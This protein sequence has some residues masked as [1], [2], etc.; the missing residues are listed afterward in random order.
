MWYPF[1]SRRAVR[2]S[3]IAIPIILATCGLLAAC[4]GGSTDPNPPINGLEVKATPA[5]AFTPS[6]LTVHVGDLVTFSFGTVPHNVFFDAT[7]G[8]P[9]DI[10]GNNA[11]VS[12]TRTFATAGQYRYTCHIH[13]GMVGTVTV[14]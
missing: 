12:V 6:A 8:A 13:P 4:G 14:Q 10:P 5:L 7:A 11:S 2:A 1:E 9:T 3:R